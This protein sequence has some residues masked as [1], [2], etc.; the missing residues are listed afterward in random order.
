MLDA[1]VVLKWCVIISSLSNAF[2]V[3]VFVW[4][5][6]RKNGEIHFCQSHFTGLNCSFAKFENFARV[7]SRNRAKFSND[8][9]S[10]VF[11]QSQSNPFVN[12][13][14]DRASFRGTALPEP[15]TTS[16]VNP[17]R[18]KNQISPLNPTSWEY[19]LNS[20]KQD[21]IELPSVGLK[22]HSLLNAAG[23]FTPWGLHCHVYVI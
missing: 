8:D 4:K 16:I 10:V 19:T 23:H 1:K 20:I 21:V 22:T 14:D 9:V 17:S 2:S 15:E 7:V 12:V 18:R 3:S 11:A 6:Q 13:I 5:R